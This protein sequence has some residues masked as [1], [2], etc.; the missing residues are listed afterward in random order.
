MDP[1]FGCLPS[2]RCIDGRRRAD[3]CIGIPG[4]GAAKP[5]SGGRSRIEMWLARNPCAD[6]A[7]TESKTRREAMGE[8]AGMLYIHVDHA[9][10]RVV[11]E[12]TGRRQPFVPITISA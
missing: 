9:V 2:G 6:I 1:E 11:S 10:G 7:H 3:C 8:I 12:D 4:R 5:E